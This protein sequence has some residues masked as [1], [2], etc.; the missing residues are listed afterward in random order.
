MRHVA[1]AAA[2]AGLAGAWVWPLPSLG[3][4]FAAHMAGHMT[5]VAFAAPLLAV[6]V[7]G[8]RLDPVVWVPAWWAAV[9]LSMLEGVAVWAWHAPA[10]HHAARHQTLAFALEQATFLATS[11]AL[12]S[13][14]LGGRREVRRSRA[15]SGIAGLLLTSMHMTL[16]GALILLAQRP[17]YGHDLW[18]EQLGG[19]IMLAAGGTAY[20]L[21]G[22]GLILD[23][24][25]PPR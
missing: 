12:W 20:L 16:L 11:F 10:L 6:S 4:P 18:D 22:L 3:S 24:N 8:T 21:G 1:L 15:L 17:L 9:P 19:A 14:A 2:I 23:L 25:R 5:L 7:A 13:A